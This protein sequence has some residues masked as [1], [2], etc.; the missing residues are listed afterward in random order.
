LSFGI[1]LR[2]TEEE[3]LQNN[4]VYCHLPYEYSLSKRTFARIEERTKCCCILSMILEKD[5]GSQRRLLGLE[6]ETGDQRRMLDLREGFWDQ[7]KRLDPREEC[8]VSEKASGPE[9][10][11]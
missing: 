8:W 11:D 2:N 5:A 1:L 7:R 4:S 6:K 10:R 3:T 9:E